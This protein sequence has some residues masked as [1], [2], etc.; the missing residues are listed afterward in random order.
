[1]TIV[2]FLHCFWCLLFS[3]TYSGVNTNSSW[4]VCTWHLL[5]GLTCKYRNL[6]L[7]PIPCFPSGRWGGTLPSSTQIWLSFVFRVKAI[8]AVPL[9]VCIFFSTLI[10]V[11]LCS[12]LSL[13]R[14]GSS[15]FC[16]ATVVSIEHKRKG[17]TIAKASFWSF[18]YKQH[19][20][21]QFQPGFPGFKLLQELSKCFVHQRNA[22]CSHIC[23]VIRL[24]QTST[25]DRF[26]ENQIFCLPANNKTAGCGDFSRA[27]KITD[28]DNSHTLHQLSSKKTLMNSRNI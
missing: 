2:Y 8:V 20:R 16:V 19:L 10:L 5:T 1:M 12:L 13:C 9:K 25:K 22:L 28:Y 27:F 18:N 7:S 26:L 15:G 21:W 3:K 6:L 23:K 24:C 14:R 4:C 11:P 17:D